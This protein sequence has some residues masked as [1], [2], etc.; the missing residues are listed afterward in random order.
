M[1][2]SSVHIVEISPTLAQFFLDCVNKC[3]DQGSKIR[4]VAHSLGVGLVP[5]V[6]ENLNNGTV[7]L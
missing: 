1:G 3:S 2:S 5:S 7:N 4:L 6:L